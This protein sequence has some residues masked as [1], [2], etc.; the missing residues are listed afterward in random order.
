MTLYSTR[1]VKIPTMRA[2]TSAFVWAS[3]ALSSVGILVSRD[4]VRNM[5]ESEDS[6]YHL[7]ESFFP[8]TR[9]SSCRPSTT[10]ILN[11]V[12]NLDTSRDQYEVIQA[13]CELPS[14]DFRSRI[15]EPETFF[16]KPFWS[17]TSYF[18][19]DDPTILVQLG[20]ELANHLGYIARAFGLV[21]WLEREY[22]VRS[23]IVLRHQEASKW[24]SARTDLTRCFPYVRW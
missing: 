4:V 19:I 9:S 21:W 8:D 12:K 18:D 20:G 7:R 10:G 17:N 6:A 1:P 24:I 23:N 13:G 14:N 22:G 2:L 15:T 11:T 16:R 3:V 5:Q